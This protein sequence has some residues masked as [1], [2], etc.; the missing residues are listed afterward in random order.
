MLSDDALMFLFDVDD[1]LLDN[2]RF[3]AELGTHLERAF[4]AAERARFWSI[5]EA[6]RERTGYADYLGTLQAFR[7]GVEDSPALPGMSSFMLD[8]PF[9]DLVYPGVFELLGHLRQNARVGILSDGDIVFQPRKIE[10]SGLSDAVGGEVLVT[11]HKERA[12]AA[13]ER[14][15][16]A[17]RYVL[18]DDKPNLLAALKRE[19][20]DRLFTVFVRQ[21]HYARAA[22]DAAAHG[23]ALADPLPDMSFDAIGELAGSSFNASL[24]AWCASRTVARQEA[25]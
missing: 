3:G 20:G 1:T 16:P 15:F 14:R 4:G 22:L 21:G 13:I 23:A 2:D 25:A 11:L 12:V 18:V 19:L 10:R 7:A 5:Y 17:R 24:A 8:Y 9:R 6:V